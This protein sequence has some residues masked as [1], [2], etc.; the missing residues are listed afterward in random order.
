[1]NNRK[2]VPSLL[3]GHI[4]CAECGA[5]MIRNHFKRGKYEYEKYRCGSRWRPFDT[6]CRGEGVT[7]S[8]IHEWLWREVKAILM[9]AEMM[10][11]E[12]KPDPEMVLNLAVVR[13]ELERTERVLQ[14]LRSNNSAE[15]LQP[16]LDREIDRASREKQQLEK[17]IAEFEKQIEE[18]HQKEAAL[19]RSGEL[20]E[21]SFDEQ[22]LTLHALGIRIYA[23]GDDPSNW[24]HEISLHQ[25]VE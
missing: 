11:E 23:N 17:V 14:G 15:E 9:N 8:V 1:M 10:L 7:L 5:H 6:S 2:S 12:V 13:R 24:R 25:T 3:R 21:L 22:R 4:F 19:R 20:D 18:A 16:Y